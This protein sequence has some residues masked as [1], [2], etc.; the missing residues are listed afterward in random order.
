MFTRVSVALIGLVLVLSACGSP[1]PVPIPTALPTPTIATTSPSS[2]CEVT[3]LE[4][5]RF[6]DYV[7]TNCDGQA[8]FECAVYDNPGVFLVGAT[9]S[10]TCL[11][12]YRTSTYADAQRA[13]HLQKDTNPKYNFVV[14]EPFKRGSTWIVSW[15]EPTTSW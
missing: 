8:D 6:T 7:D 9:L 14:D 15:T 13:Y 3:I 10:R 5:V 12:E 11:F 2:S 4:R 1:T